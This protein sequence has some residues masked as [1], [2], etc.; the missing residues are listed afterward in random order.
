MEI[1][2]IPERPISIYAL[3]CPMTNEVKYIGAS[4]DVERRFRSHLNNKWPN[5][6]M[7]IWM[8]ILKENNLQ[9]TFKVLEIL[10]TRLESVE[11]EQFYIEKYRETLVNGDSQLKLPSESI[12]SSKDDKYKVSFYLTKKELS[13]ILPILNSHS[14]S[15]HWSLIDIIK[16]HKVKYWSSLRNKV[17]WIKTPVDKQVDPLKQT[18]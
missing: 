6:K 15:M 12:F 3:I 2:Y 16:N 8:N 18:I 13:E 11:R 17:K 7:K 9:P 4:Y 1:E 10:Q 5:M 14:F